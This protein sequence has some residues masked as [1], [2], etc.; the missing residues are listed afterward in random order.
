MRAKGITAIA[1]VILLLAAIAA[2]TQEDNFQGK[3][4]GVADDTSKPLLESMRGQAQRFFAGSE[5]REAWIGYAVTARENLRGS[6][7][8]GGGDNYRYGDG[9]TMINGIVVSYPEKGILPAGSERKAI[10][11]LFADENGGSKLTRVAVLDMSERYRFELPL[12]WMAG[13]DDARSLAALR[14][15][16]GGGGSSKAIESALP[17]IALHRGDEPRKMLESIVRGNDSIDFRGDALFWLG[18]TV[19]SGD[20]G[21]LAALEKDLKDAKLREKLT[22]VYYMM[23]DER[24]TDRMIAMART[25]PSREVRK[26]A[27]F[28]MGQ[29]ATAKAKAELERVVEND[30]E[31]ELKKQAV[32]A[33]SQMNTSDSLESLLRIARTN[34]SPEVRKQAIFWISQSGDERAVDFLVDLLK[35]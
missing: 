17:A 31:V 13:V 19:D 9:M 29:L 24:A 8:S 22:F 4:N 28:W 33:L 3:V 26:Q 15:V 25:D 5:E 27:I 21:V 34:K 23:K 1:S 16:L 14:A 20:L 12:L 11:Y 7:H 32:F 2:A 6:F 35:K 18:F 30:P 10:L